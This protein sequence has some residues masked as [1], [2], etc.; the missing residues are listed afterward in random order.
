MTRRCH[1]RYLI[2]NSLPPPAA[3]VLRLPAT[4]EYMLL[5]TPVC[6]GVTAGGRRG[7]LPTGAAGDEV[8]NNP[9]KIFVTNEHR[10]EYNKVC[11][12]SQKKPVL[13]CSLAVLDRRVGHT[14]DVLSPF[15]PVLCHSRPIAT[16]FCYFGFQTVYTF[17]QFRSI[18]LSWPH[19]PLPPKNNN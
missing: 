14:M 8:Q 2:N 18:S 9:T 12:M 4:T 19:A 10:S 17:T 3:H 15:I 11:R 13:F 16:K 6:I 1:W 7:Q 5:D